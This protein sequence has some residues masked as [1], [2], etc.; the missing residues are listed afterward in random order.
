MD[1]FKSYITLILRK[2][3]YYKMSFL[4]ITIQAFFSCFF[5]SFFLIIKALL[6]CIPVRAGICG[7][8]DVHHPQKG[9]PFGKACHSIMI[10]SLLQ[11]IAV[12]SFF[13]FFK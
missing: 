3:L 1:I 4:N 6:C 11:I 10:L 9:R 13:F 5:S 8:V 12:G 2:A 7:S